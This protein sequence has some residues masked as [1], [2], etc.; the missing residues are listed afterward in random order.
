V[1]KYIFGAIFVALVWAAVSYGG[2]TPSPR[3]AKPAGSPLPPLGRVAS[4]LALCARG[5]F[6]G[7]PLIPTG[8]PA[9]SDRG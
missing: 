3:R 6:G 9:G 4:R 7:N 5:L 1:L 8:N 2:E